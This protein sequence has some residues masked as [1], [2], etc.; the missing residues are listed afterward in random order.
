MDISKVKNMDNTT[1]LTEESMDI[2]VHTTATMM[3]E[4]TTQPMHQITMI[5]TVLSIIQMTGYMMYITQRCMMDHTSMLTH[6]CMEITIR[7]EITTLL[8]IHTSM[9]QPHTMEI[10]TT[11]TVTTM[12]EPE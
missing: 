10:F 6:T 11:M 2:T 8:V 7:L 1:M 4:S 3:R 5:L 12:V 9:M